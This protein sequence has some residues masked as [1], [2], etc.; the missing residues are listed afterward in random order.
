MEDYRIIYLK[1]NKNKVQKTK[2]YLPPYKVFFE[3]KKKTSRPF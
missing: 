1:R 2:S 3:K